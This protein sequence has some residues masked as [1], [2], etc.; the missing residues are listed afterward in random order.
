MN[1]KEYVTWMEASIFARG[2]LALGTNSGENMSYT[3]V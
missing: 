1:P 3:F 2:C